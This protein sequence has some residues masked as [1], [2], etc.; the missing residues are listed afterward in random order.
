MYLPEDLYKN[1]KSRRKGGREKGEERK[2]GKASEGRR[3][4]RQDPA[5]HQQQKR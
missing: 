5:V 2:E 3:K 1:V 4:P